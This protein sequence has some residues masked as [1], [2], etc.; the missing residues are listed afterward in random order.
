MSNP[1]A[2][3]GSLLFVGVMMVLLAASI[4][5]DPGEPNPWVG[6]RFK[7]AFRSPEHWRRINQYGATM[8]IRWGLMVSAVAVFFLL[9]P[10]VAKAPAGQVAAVLLPVTIAIP[11]LITRRYAKNL[12]A[13]P[14]RAGTAVVGL[15]QKVRK[16]MAFMLLLTG[17]TVALGGT[18]LALGLVPPNH[19]FGIRFPQALVSVDNWYRVNRFGGIALAIWGASSLGAG[20]LL[21]SATRFSRKVAL[22][23]GLLYP[24]S[25]VLPVVITYLYAR[26][27]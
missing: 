12:D 11:L 6:I 25:I 1:F 19:T 16:F 18:I 23:F 8:L 2:V 10:S 27:L 17:V 22:A 26:G 4:R 21:L 14:S 7:E 15:D 9:V 20:S 3:F 13:S 5:Y 24:L